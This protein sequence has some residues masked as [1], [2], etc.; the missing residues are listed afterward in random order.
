MESNVVAIHH[1]VRPITFTLTI[2]SDSAFTMASGQT[3]V[4]VFWQAGT[5]LHDLNSVSN[6]QIVEVRG[7]LFFTGNEFNLIARRI[8][9]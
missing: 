5:D 9:Q 1:L 3:M 2:P 7:L 8:E 6:G 4:Q